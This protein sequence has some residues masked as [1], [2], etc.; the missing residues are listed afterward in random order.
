MLAFK[1]KTLSSAFAILLAL[2][3]LPFKSSAQNQRR[4]KKKKQNIEAPVTQAKKNSKKTIQDLVKGSAKIDGLFTIYQDTLTGAVQMLI[5]KEQLDKEFIY[6]SQIANGGTE[7]GRLNRGIYQPTSVFKIQKHFNKIEFIKQNT[8][9][10]FDP[11]NALSKSKGANI[12][13]GIVASLKI[14]ASDEKQ[15]QYLINPNELFLTETFQQVKPVKSPKAPPKPFTLGNLDKNKSKIK[16]INNYPENLNVAVE[17]V[18]S[19][20][21]TYQQGSKALADPRNVSIEF[22]HCFISMPEDDYEVR[23]DDPRVGFFITEVDDKTS[24]SPTPYR[25]LINRWKLKKK[26]PE[27]AISEPVKPITW[28]LENTTPIEWRETI[29]NAVLEWNK[30]FEKAGF[31][32]AI[33]VKQQP[34][35]ADWD[36][37]DIRYNVL[38]WTS[39]HKPAFG[40]YGPRMVNPKTG[41][42]L[43][44]DIMLEF[45]MISNR[46]FSSKLFDEAHS[47]VQIEH[48][49][50]PLNSESD[51]LSCSVGQQM[52]TNILLGKAYIKHSEN[53]S[54]NLSRLTK[55]GLTSTVMHEIGHT[56]GLYHNMKASHLF[57]PE[58]LADP[59]FIQGKCLTASVMDYT[60]I[61]LTK[62]PSKQGHFFD[63]SVGPYD[64][65]AIQAGYTPFNSDQERETLLN[66]STEPQLVFGND[67]DDMRSA[68]KGIDPRVNIFD[69]SNDPILYAQIQYELFDGLIK[70]LKSKLTTE[71]QSY[72]ELTRAYNILNIYKRIYA[73]VVSRYIGGIYL[74]RAV[75]GQEGG[76]KPYIPVKLE[77]QKRAMT[78][79]QQ[80]VFA[81]DALKPAEDLL[82]YLAIQRR[83]SNFLNSTYPEDP[84]IHKQILT[85]QKNVLNHLLHS[86][87]LQRISDS[88]LYGNQ[89]KLS[90]MMSNLNDA[91]FKADIY[92]NVNSFR[93]N[94]QLEYTRML[95]D[96]LNGKQSS[97]YTHRAK[98]M[99]LHNLKRIRTMAAPSGNL[100]SRAHKQHL[101]ILID[102]GLE[103]LK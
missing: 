37:G 82:N 5:E 1:F 85:S 11:N 14:E 4:N 50:Y 2:S 98:S 12:S 68:G 15:G 86:N 100:S 41:E 84:K 43:G 38:R 24:T 57:S 10:Y 52:S 77:D 8:S 79:L 34:D 21:S 3:I 63:V 36:A 20:A 90:T 74:D 16:A 76:T 13:H 78:F 28:W 9:F 51:H 81:P 17:Y 102:N 19:K 40:G 97:K 64:I 32:N 95:L 60:M 53:D 92:G 35:D 27:L 70:N 6:F 45:S 96:M 72:H 93:Q 61:N 44:A 26:H 87:T 89:Y 59:N 56:L 99:A 67:G 65:W 42:I 46:D 94:L 88:E 69:L 66:R 83:G 25:D 58:E 7:A 54:E 30:A 75:A 18:Y 49:F 29:T 73:G 47:D 103:E 55:E 62:D 91:I 31:K 48:S 22:L 71:G 101:R 33:V 80:N 23:F 39:T